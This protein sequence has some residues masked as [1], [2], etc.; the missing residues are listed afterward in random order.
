MEAGV[1]SRNIDHIRLTF[2]V[3]GLVV[4]SKQ[5]SDTCDDEFDYVLEGLF[6]V[7]GLTI[8]AIGRTYMIG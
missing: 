4:R 6:I 5:R 2:Y 7:L 3:Q 1:Q 8:I